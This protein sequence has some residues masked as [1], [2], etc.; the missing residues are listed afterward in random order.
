MIAARTIKAFTDFLAVLSKSSWLTPVRANIANPARRTLALLRVLIANS[1]VL[2]A[3]S[4]FTFKP[5]LSACTTFLTPKR[6][7]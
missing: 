1:T 5:G 6:R 3:T 2:T 7:C 4:R